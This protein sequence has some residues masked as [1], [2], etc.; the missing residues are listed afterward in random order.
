[1]SERVVG[2]VVGAHGVH[3]EVVVEVHTSLA[4]ERFAPGSQLVEVDGRRRFT[5]RRSRPH[6]ERLLV[7][8]EELGDRTTAQA[9]RGAL[10]A[11]VEAAPVPADEM[12]A[13]E[14]YGFT[15]VS[16]E[17][18]RLGSVVD[19]VANPAHDL[20]VVGENVGEVLVP[21]VKAIVVGIDTDER[22][23]VLDPPRGLFGDHEPDPGNRGHDSGERSEDQPRPRDRK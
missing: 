9:L 6:K 8:F 11:G 18:D 14:L 17:G 15:V 4:E 23:I 10:L 1:M 13:D 20:L 2:R 16:L 22:R 19:V 21:L 12:W 7:T 3:G 5:V